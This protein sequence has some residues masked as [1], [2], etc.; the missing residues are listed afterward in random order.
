MLSVVMPNVMA[1]VHGPSHLSWV[2]VA[3]ALTIHSLHLRGPMLQTIYDRNLQLGCCGHCLITNVNSDVLAYSAAV[4]SY[5]R[6]MFVIVAPE[7]SFINITSM[8]LY[9]LDKMG[10]L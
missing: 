8:W 1:L 9:S 7:T 4:V 10:K 2:S 5:S 3:R 6:K